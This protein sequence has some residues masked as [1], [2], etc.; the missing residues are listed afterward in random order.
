M[1]LTQKIRFESRFTYITYTNLFTKIG[2]ISCII[3]FLADPLLV[4]LISKPAILKFVLVIRNVTFLFPFIKKI[5]T[6]LINF[7]LIRKKKKQ[8]KQ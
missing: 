1:L 2:T 5:K 3:I 4:F 6:I 8:I 7:R